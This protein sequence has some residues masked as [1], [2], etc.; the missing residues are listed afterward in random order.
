[1]L[2][3][4]WTLSPSFTEIPTVLVLLP[5]SQPYYSQPPPYHPWLICPQG[6]QAAGPRPVAST[7]SDRNR[8]AFVRHRDVRAGGAVGRADCSTMGCHWLAGCRPGEQQRVRER[9]EGRG[10]R[11]KLHLRMYDGSKISSICPC[12]V[13]ESE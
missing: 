8:D 3:K 2:H 1:M 4:A 11:G 9:R 10:R 12:P 7:A 13:P 6:G 5:A